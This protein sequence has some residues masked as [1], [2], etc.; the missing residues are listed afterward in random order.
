MTKRTLTKAGRMLLLPRLQ[1]H[2]VLDDLTLQAIG[3]FLN[4]DRSTILRDLRG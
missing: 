1:E 2:E 3:D 4:V